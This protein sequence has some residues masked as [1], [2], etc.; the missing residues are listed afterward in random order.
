MAISFYTETIKKI[1][2]KEPVFSN[3]L[4]VQ[5]KLRVFFLLLQT[6]EKLELKGVLRAVQKKIAASFCG[7]FLQRWS[8]A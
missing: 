3:L 1:G 6:R 2:Y 7:L 5:P 8:V 4:K